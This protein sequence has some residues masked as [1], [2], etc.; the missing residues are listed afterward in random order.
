MPCIVE[1]GTL[2]K[3]NRSQHD[4]MHHHNNILKPDRRKMQY[5]QPGCG[6]RKTSFSGSGGVSERGK[7]QREKRIR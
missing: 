1:Q 2:F 4:T 3:L 5:Q 6:A 7:E